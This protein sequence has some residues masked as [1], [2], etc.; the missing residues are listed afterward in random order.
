MGDLIFDFALTPE[1]ASGVVGNLG[2]ESGLKAL[3]EQRPVRGRGGFGWAQWTGPRR[4]AFERW[5]RERDLDLTSYAANYGFLK[6]ELSGAI[7]G[8]DFRHTIT[9]VKKTTTIKAATE[10]FEAHYERA[11]VKRMSTRIEF[12]NR[13]FALFHAAS[14][15]PTQPKDPAMPRPPV[16]PMG[17]MPLPNPDPKPWYQSKAVIGGLLA[18]ILPPLAAVFPALG[19]VD[20]NTAAAYILKVIQFAA[21]LVGGMLA[22]VGRMNATQPIAG[23]RAAE[24][25]QD[26][27]FTLELARSDIPDAA[28]MPRIM[29]LPL[30][31]IL[32]ELPSVIDAI[33]ELSQLRRPLGM[34]GTVESLALRRSNEPELDAA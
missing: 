23:T 34:M 5:C 16:P 24:E 31:V 17:K 32:D 20:P 15:R 10:T 19:M 27:Q 29:S 26:A 1:Q 28:D 2:A 11:G 6:A 13:A 4:V 21:P 14:G 22:I 3:Q 30:E 25:V 9:Q 18:I 33:D 12:A 7:P 8:S